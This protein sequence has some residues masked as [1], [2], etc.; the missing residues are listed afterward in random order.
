LP[1]EVS[2]DLLAYVGCVAGAILI[3]D[4]SS[5]LRGAGFDPVEIVDTHNDLNVYGEQETEAA[6]CSTSAANVA[7][8]SALNV[9]NTSCCGPD[10]QSAKSLS[11]LLRRYN[12][13]DYA[14]SVKVYAIKPSA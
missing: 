2:S 13:T 3:D 12:I 11:E 10:T 6:A 4:Y 5:G 7:S 14:A 8:Q 9:M 1:E